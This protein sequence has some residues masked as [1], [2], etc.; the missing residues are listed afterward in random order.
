MSV[1]R[2][3]SATSTRTTVHSFDM[4]QQ[5]HS[6]GRAYTPTCSL[7]V[8]ETVPPR[9]ETRVCRGSSQSEQHRLHQTIY[10]PYM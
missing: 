7:P 1:F 10:N 8:E 4:Q 6:K 5:E 2:T 3:I 9:Q